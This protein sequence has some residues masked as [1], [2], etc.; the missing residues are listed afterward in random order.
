MPIS[1]KAIQ[2]ILGLGEELVLLSVED[3]AR[4]LTVTFYP[5]DGQKISEP[6]K[7]FGSRLKTTLTELGVKVVPYDKCLMEIPF[8]YILWRYF[9]AV[10]NEIKTLLDKISGKS[11]DKHHMTLGII[12]KIKMTKKVKP[13][14]R[15]IALGE[16]QTGNLPIDNILSFTKNPIITILD[17]P[18]GISSDSSFKE[19]FDTAARLFTHHM[20]NIVIGVGEME[21][22]LYSMN[23]SHPIYPLNENLEKNI[24]YSLIPKLSA[25]IRP[26][27]LSEFIVRR[28]AVD[29]NDA[30]HEIYVKDL[31]NSGPLLEKTGLFPKGKTIKEFDFRNEFY[32]WV[33]RVHIDHRNGMSFGFLA[34]QL[35][36]KLPALMSFQEVKNK[37]KNLDLQDKDYF[38]DESGEIIIKINTS[39]GVY[40][41]QVPEVWVLTERSGSNKTKIIPQKDIIKIGLVRGKMILVTP[42]GYKIPS[43]YKPSFDTKVILAHAAGNAIFGAVLKK[44]NPSS[45][46]VSTLETSGI[47]I[48][49]W[50]GYINPKYVPRGWHV[51]G[52]N[53]PPVSCSSPQSAIYAFQGKERAFFESFENGEEYLGDIHIEPQHGSNINFRT[54]SELGDFL[55][56]NNEIS[57]LGNKYLHQYKLLN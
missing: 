13:G 44:L 10:L 22:I 30:D 37:Y 33:G 20:T 57:A 23:A 14:I 24:L 6:V 47:A 41:L 18:E 21:W 34:R 9:K 56:S 32:E 43:Y 54:L 50:H 48:S 45:T 8:K 49:H 52:E 16:G 40:Y 42:K 19:H 31:V 5:Q 29:L 2:K 55:N 51:Y 7:I 38:L 27:L 36:V 1:Q 11:D 39:I 25:P 53:E 46:F 28:S 26:P 35:P 12:S 4:N 15:I 17:M 3:M